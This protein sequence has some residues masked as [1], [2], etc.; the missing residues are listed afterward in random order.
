MTFN[1]SILPHSPYLDPSQSIIQVWRPGHW[2]SWMFEIDSYTDNSFI[3]SK[4]GFQGARGNNNG[5]EFYIENVF[6]ELGKNQTKQNP[7][8]V[9]F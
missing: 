2:T 5:D 8:P 1:N 4:G 6:E 7:V 3:F 9:S